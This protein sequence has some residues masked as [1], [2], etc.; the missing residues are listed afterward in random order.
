MTPRVPEPPAPPDGLIRA[1]ADPTRSVAPRAPEEE[2][3]L[4][5]YVRWL[6]E[7]AWPVFDTEDVVGY[8][9]AVSATC[10]RYPSIPMRHEPAR[11]VLAPHPSSRSA[12]I[13][14][15]G[16]SLAE[17]KQPN[18]RDDAETNDEGKVFFLLDLPLLERRE[19]FTKRERLHEFQLVL[20]CEAIEASFAPAAPGAAAPPPPGPGAAVL[21]TR[22]PDAEP[23]WAERLLDI[24]VPENARPV[25][26]AIQYVGVRRLAEGAI[27]AAKRDVVRLFLTEMAQYMRRTYSFAGI[28]AAQAIGLTEDEEN[29]LYIGALLGAGRGVWVAGRDTVTDFYDTAALGV[30]ILHKVFTFVSDDPLFALKLLGS[31]T[32][33]GAGVVTYRLDAG[34]RAR[35]DRYVLGFA[36]K[37]EQFASMMAQIAVAAWEN[38]D[39]LF[40]TI[41]T[42]IYQSFDRDFGYIATEYMGYG[43]QSMERAYFVAAFMAADVGAYIGTVITVE[44][45]IGI[46]TSGI[47]SYVSA[48]AKAG[49]LR[50]IEPVLR[51]LRRVYGLIEGVGDALHKKAAKA[52]ITIIHFF[53]DIPGR[54]IGK[55]LDVVE[56]RLERVVKMFLRFS[57]D[58]G[59]RIK[60]LVATINNVSPSPEGF[61]R[62]IKMIVNW[63]D[64]VSYKNAERVWPDGPGFA[65]VCRRA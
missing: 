28:S 6:V 17:L 49:R 61:A 25:V 19:I 27:T 10:L 29:A 14:G 57:E 63:A 21:A 52:F 33:P 24:L 58:A 43:E 23:G 34:F 56:D 5:E 44:V 12:T 31:L 64:G 22:A 32:V 60:A 3:P 46:A 59:E 53:G 1:A 62:Y 18:G 8:R 50:R 2:P 37:A 65:P 54:Y 55:A 35:I 47:G 26:T 45:L 4:E 9:A 16:S 38:R 42:A 7:E 39:V 41:S 36:Q 13:L 30:T 48:L 51:A 20:G 15:S 11:L 40:Q